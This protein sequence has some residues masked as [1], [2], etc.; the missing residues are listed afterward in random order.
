MSYLGLIPGHTDG[1]CD[2]APVRLRSIAMN[3]SIC[4]VDG[5]EFDFQRPRLV[6]GWRAN[7]LIMSP[8]HSGQL[9]LLP[10]AGWSMTLCGWEVKVKVKVKGRYGSVDLWINVWVAGK[11][12]RSLVNTRHS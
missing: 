3:E 11:T 12:V 1:N 5:R 10:S 7:H 9:S 2:F 4:R 6:L 8:S